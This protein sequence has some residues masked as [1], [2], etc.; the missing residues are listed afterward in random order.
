MDFENSP[1]TQEEVEEVV[2]Q[3]EG[4]EPQDTTETQDD[5]SQAKEEYFLAVDERT[6]YRTKEDALKAYQNAGTR[7]KELSVWEKEVGKTY[8]LNP[9]QVK[10]VLAEYVKMKEASKAPAK[11]EGSAT[12]P[13]LDPKEKAAREWM[14]KALADELGMSVKDVKARLAKLDAI[15]QKTSSFE[16]QQEEAKTNQYHDEQRSY[17]KS[18]LT[19]NGYLGKPANK[20]E[21][22]A[23]ARFMLK[24]ERSIKAEI[25]SSDENLEKYYEGGD[26]TREFLASIF[27]DVLET[28]GRTPKTAKAASYAKDKAATLGRNPAKLPNGSSSSPTTKKKLSDSEWH[29]AAWAAAQAAMRGGEE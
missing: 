23:Q 18:W 25:E 7:I 22:D 13:T 21:A 17:L 16:K 10:T 9:Q 29:E 26:T 15:E 14:T 24:L 27:K 2:D 20:Q 1:G 11:A 3:Q 8:G 6:K 5:N 12:E 19:D 28:Y 4:G